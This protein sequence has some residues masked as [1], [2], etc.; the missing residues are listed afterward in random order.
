MNEKN[1]QSQIDEINK[2][3]DI[4][5]EEIELQRRKRQE[6]E[7]LRDDLARI[8]KDIYKAAIVELEEVHDSIS[9]GDIMHLGKKMLRNVNNFKL[10]I[11]QIESIR[12][13]IRDIGPIFRELTFDAM[14]KLDE[15]DRKGYFEKIKKMTLIIDKL[16][17]NISSN[18]LEKFGNIAE[19]FLTAIKETEID[20]NKKVSIFKLIKNLS[21]QEV[22]R[23]AIYIVS[24]LKNFSNKL[25]TN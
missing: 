2:K 23:S 25:K 6:L 14:N 3:L 22:R 18:D 15:I 8:S 19:N 21:S 20:V 12:D 5:L 16:N 24:V 4:V 11:D 1:I 17:E 10:M 13:F 9:T 7:D